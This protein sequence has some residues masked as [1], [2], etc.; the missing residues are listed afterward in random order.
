L[1]GY[2]LIRKVISAADRATI[3]AWFKARAE[4]FRTDTDT[5]RINNW[6]TARLH[7]FLSYGY[8]LDEVVYRNTY[9][10]RVNNFMSKNLY[11]N[12]TTQDLIHRD[13]F[14]YHAYDL[15]FYARICNVKALFEGYA[16]ADQFYTKDVKWG[17]SLKK[18]VDFWIPYLM[19]PVKNPHRE[20][21]DTQYNPDRNSEKYSSYNKMY[22]PASTIYVVNE[23]Y[24]VDKNA[25]DPVLKKYQSNG[26]IT[27]NLKIWLSAM[28]WYYGEGENFQIGT[29]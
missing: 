3:D 7:Q 10:S 4:I 13:A 29:L 6:E 15:L 16:A 5:N 1:E 23:L 12:G 18:C 14:A 21:A 24:L 27:A 26:N 17:A 9:D 19:D 22:V 11:P 20:F 2:S 25:L 8:V 28:R